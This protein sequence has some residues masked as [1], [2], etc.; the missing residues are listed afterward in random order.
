MYL[1]VVND[2]AQCTFLQAELD[3]VAEANLVVDTLHGLPLVTS[4]EE[5]DWTIRETERVL[6]RLKELRGLSLAQKSSSIM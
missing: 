2:E 6:D 3:Y 5:I 4:P 1:L